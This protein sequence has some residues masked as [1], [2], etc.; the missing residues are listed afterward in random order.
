MPTRKQLHIIWESQSEFFGGTGQ[1]KEN[2]EGNSSPN[3]FTTNKQHEK[4]IIPKKSFNSKSSE[5]LG[6][7]EYDSVLDDFKLVYNKS[8]CEQ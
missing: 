4:P 7:L 8:K 5:I 1:P 3:G 6:E 2:Y